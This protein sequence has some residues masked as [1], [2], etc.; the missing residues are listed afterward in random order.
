MG[1]VLAPLLVPAPSINPPHNSTAL[2]PQAFLVESGG[3]AKPEIKGMYNLMLVQALA[4]SVVLAL[5]F[6]FLQGSIFFPFIFV[7]LTHW[8][9]C[10]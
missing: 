6:L 4:G 1:S 7:S 8:L 5:T 10:L 2:A 9:H 3:Q